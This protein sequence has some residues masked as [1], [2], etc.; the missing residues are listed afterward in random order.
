MKILYVGASL[1]HAD[2]RAYM[3]KL[4]VVFLKFENAFKN[5]KI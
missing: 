2:G 5:R 4:I 3:K 1:F